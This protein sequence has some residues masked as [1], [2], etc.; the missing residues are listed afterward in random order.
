MTLTIDLPDEQ[1][2]AL[3]AQARELGL[4]MEE[5]IRRALE[6][7]VV[8]DWLQQAWE[9]SKQAGLDQLSP[10]EIDAE[11]AAA[12]KARRESRLRPES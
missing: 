3:A 10:A 2:A 4:S 1:T 5:Y 8:P 12:R 6:R 9:T 11:I 7:Q